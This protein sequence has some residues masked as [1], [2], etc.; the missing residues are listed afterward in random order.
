MISQ[1]KT[2][3]LILVATHKPCL[4]PTD[5][6]FVPIHC[7]RAISRLDSELLDW[8]RANTIGDDTGE[9]IS[10]LNSY[11]CELTALYW[12]WKNYNQLGTPDRIGLCHYR[13]FFMDLGNEK[14]ITVPVHYLNKTIREQFNR[15][16]NP[17]ELNRA[18]S[19]LPSQNLRDDI[20]MYLNQN[21]GYFFNMFVLPKEVF[22]E[23]CEIIFTVLFK[24]IEICSWKSLSSYQQRMP[25][26]I[27]ERL[28]GGIIYHLHKARHIPIHE[29]LTI[30]PIFNSYQLTKYQI[31]M[32]AY[33]SKHI[34]NFPKAY[35]LFLSAQ[36]HMLNH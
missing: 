1:K 17:E 23:Y 9:N 4:L 18:I 34:S 33:L 13:R 31:G 5:D 35:S 12:A 25:G 27:A 30:V 29:T 16:H 14:E 32:T 6:I 11:F 36:T 20:E 8:M 2:K 26:F 21:K 3:L 22:F 19:L 15:H 10:S 24:L 28:T 7:G